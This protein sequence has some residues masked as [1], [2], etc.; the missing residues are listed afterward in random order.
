MTAVVL[1]RLKRGDDK[2][3]RDINVTVAGDPQDLTDTGWSVAAQM[4][5]Q[6]NAATAVDFDID[7]SNLADSIVSLSLTRAVTATLD[8]RSYVGDVQITGPGGR[9]SSTTFQVVVEADVTREP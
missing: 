8:A 4:R 1:G 3:F 5:T 7:E 6:S 2:V 9:Q